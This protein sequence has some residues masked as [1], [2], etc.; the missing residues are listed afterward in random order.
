MQNEGV[1]ACTS[2]RSIR[3]G[4]STAV[5]APCRILI[6]ESVRRTRSLSPGA[7]RED[8][9]SAGR[10]GVVWHTQGSGK[11][12]TMAFYAGRVILHPAT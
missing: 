12:L 6:P 11:S 9:E 7:E 8:D 3:R 1:S 5:P 2:T 4:Q 10:G